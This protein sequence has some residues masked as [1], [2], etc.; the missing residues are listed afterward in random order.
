MNA[1][2]K[3][4]KALFGGILSLFAKKE[5]GFRMDAGPS[6]NAPAVAAALATKAVIKEAE[7]VVAT[8]GAKQA[9]GKAAKTATKTTAVAA[10]VKAPVA[11]DPLDLINAALAASKVAT[12]EAQAVVGSFA[13]K[14]LIANPMPTRR[15]G[16]NMAMFKDMAKSMKRF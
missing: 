7:P 4:F 6:E 9:S 8:K 1:I 3:I 12:E 5:G 14:Y 15:P 16:A 13:D 10:A 11:A 2:V